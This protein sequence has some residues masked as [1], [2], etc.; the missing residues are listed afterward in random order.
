VTFHARRKLT[1][2]LRA[3]LASRHLCGDDGA[4]RAWLDIACG[5]FDHYADAFVAVV[6]WRAAADVRGVKTRW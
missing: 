6:I 3:G 1:G 2:L 4:V 5:K